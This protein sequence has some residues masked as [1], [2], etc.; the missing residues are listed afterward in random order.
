MGGGG[1]QKYVSRRANRLFKKGVGL[2]SLLFVDLLRSSRHKYNAATI[3]YSILPV[4]VRT[5][6][7]KFSWFLWPLSHLCRGEMRLYQYMN[8]IHIEKKKRGLT[9]AL[10]LCHLTLC[11]HASLFG[12]SALSHWN[13][14]V[15]IQGHC[16]HVSYCSQ[17]SDNT[18]CL[19]HYSDTVLVSSLHNSHW[20]VN[21]GIVGHLTVI[22]CTVHWNENTAIM[23]FGGDYTPTIYSL[24]Y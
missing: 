15:V 4:Q 21:P 23:H 13:N 17:Y 7:Q 16:C 20:N 3:S 24:V 9:S 12:L 18:W 11:W 19:Y 8:K 22:F 14:K 1:G 5:C 2:S 10:G 6:L